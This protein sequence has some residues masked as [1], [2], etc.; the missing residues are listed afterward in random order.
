M[1]DFFKLIFVFFLPLFVL[2]QND[3]QDRIKDLINLRE[4]SK[5]NNLSFEEKEKL[6]K[7][8]LE[9]ANELKIDSSILKS[10][11]RL[12]TIYLNEG[13]YEQYK[14]LNF[15]N[16]KL[17]RKVNDSTA[18]SSALFNIGQYYYSQYE[19][20]SAY[21]YFSKAIKFYKKLGN[22]EDEAFVLLVISDIQE[23]ERDY[24]GS[25]EN[26]I[27]AIKMFESFPKT[28]FN[29]AQIYNLNN[30]LGIIS[31]KLGNYDKS[32]E[33]HN[34]A[35]KVAKTMDNGFYN[36]IFSINNKA[37]VYRKKKN[38]DEALD[39]YN[40]LVNIRDQ[41][42]DYDPTFYPLII[43][44]IAYTKLI[45]GHD[46]YDKMESLFS[47]AFH[48]SDSLKDDITKLAVSI[49]FSKFY[50][51]RQ[52]PD[53][54]LK[55]VNIAYKIA[56]ETSSNDILL[57]ALKV[58]SELKEG[59]EGK[60]YLIEHITL[61]DSLLNVERNVRDKFARIAF[62]T[63]KIEEENER[64]SQQRMWLLIV[65][66]VLLVTLFLLYIIIT[67]RAK[68][69]ELQFEKDQQKANEEIYN[70]MLSQQD[71]VDEARANEKKRISQEMHD[72]ILGRLF[73]T[74]LSLDSLNFSEGKEAIQNRSNYINE[75]KTIEDDIRKISHDL[76]TDFVSGSG[77]MDIVSELIEKQTSAYQLKSKFDYTDDVSWEMVSN[78]NKINIYRIIQ[79][80][81][82]NIYKHANAETVKISFQLKNNVILLSITDDGSGFD[83]N[84]SKKGIGIKNINARVNDLEGTVEIKSKIK[85]GTTIQIK[86]PYKTN[87]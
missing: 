47:K 34:K 22:V 46:D 7:Q 21:Y 49:D 42:D 30:L 78:K 84:K 23:T 31:L 86:I 79:E 39:L 29:L 83:V 72:G 51:K 1:K 55:Y 28:E 77:F 56:K 32:L 6:A 9:I 63:D 4:Q 44:N 81:L 80:S 10:K 33:Y 48:I 52:M 12:S 3:N 57:D 37:F 15:E 26:A 40:S 66:A 19:N 36:E 18:T 35:E 25:E 45:A 60:T 65:S 27:K 17:A 74:R 11:R 20:D 2:A 64:I 38:Y 5:E 54:S 41:Y 76:N 50:L 70:L 82:Q 24:I 53:S 59:E 75:L 16:L 69:K 8:S 87:P 61:S 62:E 43:D 71:K 85:E 14:N 68:N 58:L 67:Q 73:G 13:K